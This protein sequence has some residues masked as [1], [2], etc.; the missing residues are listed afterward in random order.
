MI[1]LIKLSFRNIYNKKFGVAFP[2]KFLYRNLSSKKMFKKK[3]ILTY[4]TN[5]DTMMTYVYFKK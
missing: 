5:S 1:V 3:I 2:F 4:L